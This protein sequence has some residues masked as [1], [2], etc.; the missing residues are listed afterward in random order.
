V[1]NE[2]AVGQV[3]AS[4]VEEM[5]TLSRNNRSVH[6]SRINRAKNGWIGVPEGLGLITVFNHPIFLPFEVDSRRP[7]VLDFVFNMVC[8]L[9][10]M[11]F[12]GVFAIQYRVVVIHGW[13]I[14]GNGSSLIEYGDFF[15]YLGSHACLTAQ[16]NCSIAQRLQYRFQC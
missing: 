10:T 9:C 8:N 11:C 2:V 12:S 1:V 15:S 14:V 16:V 3:A 7:I 5:S 6:T 4:K 13:C